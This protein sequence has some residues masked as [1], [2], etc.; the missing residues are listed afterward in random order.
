MAAV[1]LVLQGVLG[2]ASTD[3]WV[4]TWPDEDTRGPGSDRLFEEMV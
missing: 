2:A 1:L 4:T 3:Q